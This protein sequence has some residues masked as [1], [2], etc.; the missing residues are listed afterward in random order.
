MRDPWLRADIR[1]RIKSSL[2][3]KTYLLHDAISPMPI[4]IVDVTLERAGPWV[5]A[6]RSQRS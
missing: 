4:V 1:G 5:D 2:N 6:G 3:R